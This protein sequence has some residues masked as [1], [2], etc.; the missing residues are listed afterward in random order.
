MTKKTKE[1]ETKEKE[2]KKI[3]K[4]ILFCASEAAPFSGSGG[5]GE[6]MGSLPVALAKKRKYDVRVVVPLYDQ[7]SDEWRKKMKFIKYFYVNLSWRHQ[8]CG[9]FELKKEGVTYYFIDNEFYFRR[10]GLYGFYDDGERFAY[11]SR[12]IMQMM[13]EIDF[14]PDIVHAND[15]QSALVPVYNYYEFHY[16]FKSVFTI[17][18]IAYQGQY[19]LEIMG[20]LFG[21]PPEAGDALEFNGCINLLKGAIE[22][23]SIVNTVSETY[24]KELQSPEFSYGL[25]EIIRK[26][27]FKIRGIL[28]GINTS[29]YDPEKDEFITAKYS[30]DDLKGKALCKEHLQEISGL[31]KDPDATVIALVSRLVDMKGVELIRQCIG[32]VMEK[33]VQFVV[34]GTG[35]KYYEDFFKWLAWRYQGRVAAHIRFDTKLSHE[36][37]AGADMFLMPSMS[38]PCGLSQMIACKYGTVPV[39]RETGGLKDTIKDCSTG[40]GNGFTFA[41]KDQ[42]DLYDAI[43]R[44]L[45]LYDKKRQW[46]ALV[47]YIMGLDFSWKKSAGVYAK[48]YDE[49]L[50]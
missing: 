23:S 49:L 9:L 50:G 33:R 6:V 26:N 7:V 31:E 37:Y 15:W 38:E 28:N 25:D 48:M 46:Q 5:L 29:F 27:S 24:A 3:K 30:A 41:T 34:L 1:K 36:V 14:Y 8:Y 42:A 40:E 20:D 11:F 17:H 43:I 22:T 44:G 47:K 2:T 39:V 35:D 45:K 32:G 12:A 10:G 13:S 18:N 19:G 16:S 4:S 21:L